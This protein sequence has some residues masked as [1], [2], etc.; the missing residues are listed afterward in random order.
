MT[1]DMTERS[2]AAAKQQIRAGSQLRP[3]WCTGGGSAGW[4]RLPTAQRTAMDHRPQHKAVP[5]SAR[6]FHGRLVQCS[7]VVSTWQ[8]QDRTV[9]HVAFLGRVL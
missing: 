5:S 4:G 8:R 3:L 6:H 1:D 9:L 2:K 7:T